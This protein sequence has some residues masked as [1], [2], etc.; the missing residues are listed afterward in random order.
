MEN[1]LDKLS[2]V[3]SPIAFKLDS[4]RYLTAVKAGFFGAMSLLIIGSIFLLFANLPI[5]SYPGFMEGLLGADW[6]SYFQVPYDM[7][8]EIMTPFVMIGMAKSLANYYKVDD[9][10][11]I[12]ISLVAFFVLTPTITAAN[13]ARGIPML[14][15]SA[16]GLFVGMISA[17]IATEIY[18]LVIQKGW[19]IKLP[20]SVPSNVARSFSALVPGFIVIVLFNF[21]RIGFS[22]ISYETAHAFIFEI[23]QTPL[24]ALSR[25]LPTTFIIFI[26]EGLLWSFGIHGSN[27]VGAVM[28]PIWLNL[29]AENATAFASGT[30]LPN[31]IN[32]QFYNNFIKVGGAGATLGLALCILM[33]AR[34]E[35]YKTLGKLAFV[36]GLFNINEPLI[37]GLP[38]VLNPIMMIPFLLMPLVMS[39]LTYFV[40][41]AGIV[42]Y[43]NGAN[44]PWT[45]PPIISGFLLSGWRGGAWQMVQILLSAGIYYPFFRIVDQK[46]YQLETEGTESVEQVEEGAVQATQPTEA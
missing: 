14:N 21:I 33:F 22:L 42:P 8:M 17:I 44:I 25:T 35:Q 37:F 19:V 9:I 10:G 7:T 29:T 24:L 28:N 34:S 38:I 31:I 1:A 41:S 13:E 12:L 39:G 46:A 3:L 6:K 40:M 16:S 5:E 18:R 4:N 36:P 20:D 26:F 11:A 23:L 2:D 43:A 45:T 27:I 32:A 30:A 15:L